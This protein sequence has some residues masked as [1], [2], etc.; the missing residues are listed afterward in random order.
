ML[1]VQ[2]VLLAQTD[3]LPPRETHTVVSIRANIDHIFHTTLEAIT[4]LSSV[5]KRS[6][7]GRIA[8]DTCCPFVKVRLDSTQI[9]PV[10]ANSTSTFDPFCRFTTPSMKFVSPI[11]SAT[12]LLA[13]RS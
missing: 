12:Y 7:S 6:F 2:D 4:S 5:F 10:L 11:K 8:T 1:P 13:G 9:T 3:L